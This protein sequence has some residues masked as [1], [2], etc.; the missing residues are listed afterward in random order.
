[1]LAQQDISAGL[2]LGC[3]WA[4][5]GAVGRKQ[6]QHVRPMITLQRPGGTPVGSARTPRYNLPCRVARPGRPGC[7]A[8]LV[9]VAVA[10]AV[11]RTAA[12]AAGVY[13]ARR[14]L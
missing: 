11:A 12:L 5:L 9:A 8:R 6:T 3:R 1:M 14:C 4:Q 2:P 13:A 7:P 10:A